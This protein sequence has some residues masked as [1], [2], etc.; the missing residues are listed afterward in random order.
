MNRP[1]LFQGLVAPHDPPRGDMSAYLP[2]LVA[3]ADAS[4]GV[5]LRRLIVA[6]LFDDT[7]RMLDA[8]AAHGPWDAVIGVPYSSNRPGVA[9]RWGPR[10]GDR[11]HLPADLDAL[12][13]V[14][15]DQL[16]R[17]L[18]D[19]R[20]TGRQLVAMDVGGFVAPLLH[21][22]FRDQL[23]LVRGVVEI[24]KQGVWRAQELPLAFPVL[25]C[26]DSEMKRLEA[27]RCGETIARCLDGAFRRLGQS[28]AG[29]CAT[30]FGA[31]WIGSGVARALRRLDMIVELV[32]PDP[33]KLVEA[34]LNGF[35]ASERPQALRRASLV[36]GAS[37]RRSI[38]AEILRRLPDGAMVASGSSRQVEIDVAALRAAPPEP[39]GPGLDAV[40]APGGRR[41]ILVNDGYPAN[42]LPGS[43]SV[44]D[45]IVELILGQMIVLMQALTERPHAPGVHRITPEQE[46]E[47]ARLWLRLRDRALAP[48]QETAA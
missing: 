5:G 19:C 27:Q 3:A 23:H 31:G 35:S 28:M 41:L 26:A 13:T 44:A 22:C 1:M 39:I 2:E 34:R 46:A 10:F 20:A 24:T 15:I 48:S 8:L 40:R 25:H 33:L 17:A 32:D 12:E 6:H 29:R 18:A 9:E 7:L 4:A 36:I 38:D 11:L 43:D 14:L 47:G 21:A 45:E 37:G 30:V 16:G 42:F